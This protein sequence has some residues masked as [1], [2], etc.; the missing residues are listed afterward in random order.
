MRTRPKPE[1][2]RAQLGAP[3]STMDAR[4]SAKEQK[5]GKRDETTWSEAQRPRARTDYLVEEMR[6][7][8]RWERIDG[9]RASR[10][11]LYRDQSEKQEGRGGES[12]ENHAPAEEEKE[13][14]LKCVAD[15][16]TATAAAK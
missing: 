12:P 5:G 9:V 13:G 2:P 8:R 15:K 3:A 7:C 4:P 6:N 1:S 16:L 14:S 10:A 11:H